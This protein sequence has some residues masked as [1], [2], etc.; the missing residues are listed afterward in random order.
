MIEIILINGDG[1]R[2]LLHDFILIKKVNIR[3]VFG[4]LH[5]PVISDALGKYKVNYL[6][7][8]YKII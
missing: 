4:L 8:T 1:N 3:T 2:K 7:F 5:L 6:Q